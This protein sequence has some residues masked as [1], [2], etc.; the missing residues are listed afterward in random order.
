M[1]LPDTEYNSEDLKSEIARALVA[2]RPTLL[3]LTHPADEH[4]DHC[5]TYFLV[6]EALQELRTRDPTLY[7]HLLTFLIHFGQW[8][9]GEGAGTGAR[10]SPPHGFAKNEVIW[11]PFPLSPEETATK[12]QALLQY[13]S[14]MLAMGRYLLSFARANELFAWDSEGREVEKDKGRCCQE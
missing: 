5:A 3:A 7:P 2:F 12:R 10:L 4:P 13:H 6:R 14:Q 11:M 8:P 1:L 9:I